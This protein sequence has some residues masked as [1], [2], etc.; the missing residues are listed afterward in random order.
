MSA[1]QKET[2]NT[3]LKAA[4]R[5]PATIEGREFISGLENLLFGAQQPHAIELEQVI[6][7]ACLIDNT[8]FPT[9]NFLK[10]ECFYQD[11]NAII[12]DAFSQLAEKEI[13][14]DLVTVTDQ[15]RKMKKWRVSGELNKHFATI[16]KTDGHK[17]ALEAIG[18]GYY[19]VE[20]TNRVTSSANLEYHARIIYQKY[21]L[22]EGIRE[23]YRFLAKAYAEEQDVFELRNE[24]AESML[25]SSPTSYFR[26][27]T[28]NEVMDDASKIQEMHRLAGELLHKGSITILFAPPGVGKSIVA[29][30]IGNAIAAGES[31]FPGILDNELAGNGLD[32]QGEKLSVLFLDMELF[33]KEIE[34]RYSYEDQR[35]HFAETFYRVDPNPAFIDYPDEDMDKFI[36]R[37][38][39]TF[40]RQR[41]PDV[42][43]VD[44]ITALSNESASDP[45]IAI[46]I[47][48]F[49]KRLRI[50]YNLTILVLAHTTK[51]SSKTEQIQLSS[52]KGASA[53]QDM[54]PC[55]WAIGQNYM[56]EGNAYYMKQLKSRNGEKVNGAENVIKVRIGQEK[57]MLKYIFDG[58]DHEDNCLKSFMDQQDQ[59]DFIEKAVKIKAK[60]WSK[61]WREIA[62]EINFPYSHVTLMNRCKVFVAGSNQY[63]FDA[64]GNIIAAATDEKPL[65]PDV[66]PVSARGTLDEI[67]F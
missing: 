61:G 12:F 20:L 67:P 54:A 18:G 33:D 4:W 39:E 16:E 3:K 15:L 35:Y 30:Q 41:M 1:I 53:F 23:A 9:V 59:D 25:V 43:I 48:R 6:L 36:T 17:H 11:I 44:N 27:R 22:R 31:L 50:K 65:S 51:Y 5:N 60:D 32:K 49:L 14:I 28:W 42:L 56:E 10:T 64:S 52:M 40:V 63:E 7:G 19:L 58:L 37:Q 29:V 24:L 13:P 46:K 2:I 55:I 62:K 26:I 21:L 45:N 66:K 8:A 34:K 57:G 38:I 47:M